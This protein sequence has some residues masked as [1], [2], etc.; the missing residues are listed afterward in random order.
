MKSVIKHV[1]DKDALAAG[2]VLKQRDKLL[3]QI[4][5]EEYAGKVF[6]RTE[7]NDVVGHCS[8]RKQQSRMVSGLLSSFVGR[9]RL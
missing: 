4:K 8:W 3:P 6:E 7:S 9:S 1:W 5:L 2:V